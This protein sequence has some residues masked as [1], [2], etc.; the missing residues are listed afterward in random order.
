MFI[1]EQFKNESLKPYEYLNQWLKLL[2]VC[3]LYNFTL[4]VQKYLTNKIL[5]MSY[6]L[7]IIIICIIG[8]S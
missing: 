8:I 4:M 3:Q 5:P 2:L 7:E 1:V 6:N